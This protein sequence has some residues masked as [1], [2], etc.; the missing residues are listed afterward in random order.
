MLTS[1]AY[2]ALGKGNSYVTRVPPPKMMTTLHVSN[3]IQGLSAL[4]LESGLHVDRIVD[5]K[6]Y[7]PRMGNSNLINETIRV[8]SIKCQ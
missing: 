5:I 6:Y 4:A 7:I 2:R 1:V 3:Y 8:E